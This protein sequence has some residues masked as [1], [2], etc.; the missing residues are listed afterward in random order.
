MNNQDENIEETESL[1]DF[2]NEEVEDEVD[3]F[4]VDEEDD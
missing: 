3:E 1:D 2:D 4:A